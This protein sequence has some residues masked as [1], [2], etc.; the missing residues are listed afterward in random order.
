MRGASEHSWHQALP[1]CL[2]LRLPLRSRGR[3]GAERT[4]DERREQ[5]LAAAIPA[6]SPGPS[7]KSPTGKQVRQGRKTTPETRG[8]QLL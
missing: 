4:G 7:H 2:R 6:Y 3:S 5:G 1:R 8:A